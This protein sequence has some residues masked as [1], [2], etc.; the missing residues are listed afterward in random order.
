MECAPAA[1]SQAVDRGG[2]LPQNGVRSMVW[3]VGDGVTAA[4]E[5]SF[6]CRF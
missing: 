2:K 5:G 3:G 4:A 1:Q 6:S